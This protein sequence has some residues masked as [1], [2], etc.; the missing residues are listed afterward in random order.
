MCVS[1]WACV[2]VC[3]CVSSAVIWPHT[4]VT[5]PRKKLLT[6]WLTAPFLTSYPPSL[7]PTLCVL[8]SLFL[9]TSTYCFLSLMCFFLSSSFFILSFPFYSPIPRLSVLIHFVPFLHLFLPCF[10][11]HFLPHSANTV[12]L[13]SNTSVVMTTGCN[14]PSGCHD[15]RDTAPSFPSL[16]PCVFT[17]RSAESESHDPA[18]GV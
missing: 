6:L 11:I 1:V 2:C 7:F 3:V 14:I 5:T 17:V 15:N 4:H 13:L 9:V 12:Q 10:L 8:V 16:P 18:W